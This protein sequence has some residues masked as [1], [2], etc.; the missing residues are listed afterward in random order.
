MTIDNAI[1]KL[2]DDLLYD[3]EELCSLWAWHPGVG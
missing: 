1:E 3:L 2:D